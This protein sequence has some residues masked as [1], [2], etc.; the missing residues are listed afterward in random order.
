MSSN[1]VQDEYKALITEY[2]SMID[3]AKIDSVDS[4]VIQLTTKEKNS[5]AIKLSAVGWQVRN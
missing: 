3:A 2:S 1:F 5:F 4:S